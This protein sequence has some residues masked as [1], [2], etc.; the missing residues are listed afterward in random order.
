[1]LRLKGKVSNREPIR[2]KLGPTLHRESHQK[3]ITRSE[4]RFSV[5]GPARIESKNLYKN[6]EYF[7]LASGIVRTKM[8]YWFTYKDKSKCV[9]LAKIIF[10]MVSP[11][12]ATTVLHS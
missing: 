5:V 3:Y 2:I 11:Y 8:V 9:T 6:H 4:N 12:S 10:I 1:M 7:K